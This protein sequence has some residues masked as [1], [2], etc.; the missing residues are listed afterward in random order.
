[1]RSRIVSGQRWIMRWFRSAEDSG[2]GGCGGVEMVKETRTISL[3]Y[4]ISFSL[5][6]FSKPGLA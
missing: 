3:Y 5:F 4:F 2:G 1:M 6:C